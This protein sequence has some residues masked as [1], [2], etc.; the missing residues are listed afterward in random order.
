MKLLSLPTIKNQAGC[1]EGGRE[2]EGE[3]KRRREGRKRGLKQLN[4]K[5]H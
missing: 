1:R 2:E 3:G 4:L 5:G